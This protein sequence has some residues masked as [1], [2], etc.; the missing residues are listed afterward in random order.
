MCITKLRTAITSKHYN[1]DPYPRWPLWRVIHKNRKAQAQ[2]KN[3]C[4]TLDMSYAKA[5]TSDSRVAYAG[6]VPAEPK[7]RHAVGAMFGKLIKIAGFLCVMT[8]PTYTLLSFERAI[9]APL[10]RHAAAWFDRK[11]L[12][13]H[14]PHQVAGSQKPRQ[15]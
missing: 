12:A 10:R 9:G 5:W 11:G 6:T 14:V 15:A 3:Q 2:L 8:L 1:P 7:S 4:D 13:L